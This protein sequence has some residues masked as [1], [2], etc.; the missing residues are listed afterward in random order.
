M[1]IMVSHADPSIIFIETD[2]NFF[3]IGEFL[4]NAHQI[5]NHN[6]RIYILD[7]SDFLSRLSLTK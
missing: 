6:T 1:S 4:L 2:L 5:L 3:T 7:I